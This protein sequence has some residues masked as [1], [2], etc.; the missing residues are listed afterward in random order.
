MRAIGSTVVA[1]AL[2]LSASSAFA[3]KVVTDSDASANFKAFKTY[4]WAKGTESPN[5]LGEKR[6]HDGVD[7]KMKAAGFTL[8]TEKPDVFVATHAVAKEQKELYTMGMG[9]YGPRWGGGSGT[10]T[11]NTYLV[12]TLAVD[13]YDG[14]TKQLIWRGTATDTLDEKPEKNAE[15]IAKSL[16]K[17][18]KE[19]PPKVKK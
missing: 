4:A 10:T 15:K 8:V 6:I 16:E 17:M 11:V 13:L 14:K 3:Q 19:Y 12:G 7:A 1:V 9:G 18:F 5:P 2:I